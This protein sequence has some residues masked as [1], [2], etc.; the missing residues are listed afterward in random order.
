MLAP[1]KPPSSYDC[2]S[3]IHPSRRWLRMNASARLA[4]R[5]E[6]VKFLIESFFGRLARVDRAAQPGLGWSR[7]LRIT[8]PHGEALSVRLPYA[9]SPKKA[10]PFQRVPVT[11]RAMALS[12]E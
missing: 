5:V 7:S 12:E 3:A 10:K 11:A 4:L 9:V 2:G 1:V 6:R 8:L